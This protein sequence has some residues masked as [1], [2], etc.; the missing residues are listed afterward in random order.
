MSG[1]VTLYW[2]WKQH[3]MPASESTQHYLG[4][5]TERDKGLMGTGASVALCGRSS[6]AAALPALTGSIEGS[7]EEAEGLSLC[8][9]L[10]TPRQHRGP[11]VKQ[12]TPL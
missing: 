8:E 5:L 3:L 12:P 11:P 2:V 6:L 9:T 4:Q 7:Q 1:N 10:R